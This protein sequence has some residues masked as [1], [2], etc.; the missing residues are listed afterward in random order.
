MPPSIRE[1]LLPNCHDGRSEEWGGGAVKRWCAPALARLDVGRCSL[2]SQRKPRAFATG[3]SLDG[4]GG[5][6]V[7]F[8]VERFAQR[9]EAL[10]QL[11]WLQ[12]NAAVAIR[13]EEEIVQVCAT[14]LTGRASPGVLALHHMRVGVGNATHIFR[15]HLLRGFANQGA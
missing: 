6:V 1:D 3:M 4:F 7:P 5:E 14:S 11:W 2:G 13:H 8:G 15:E 10:K 12:T 9:V